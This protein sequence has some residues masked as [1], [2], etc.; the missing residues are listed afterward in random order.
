[1]IHIPA[2]KFANENNEIVCWQLYCQHNN[3]RSKETWKLK[4]DV[5]RDVS[6][7]DLNSGGGKPK[8]LHIQE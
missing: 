4:K 6:S 1:M 7:Q 3:F 8:T 5:D 2:P